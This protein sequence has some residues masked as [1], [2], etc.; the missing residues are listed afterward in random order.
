MTPEAFTAWRM[1]LGLTKEQAAKR[2]GQ[3]RFTIQN[4]ESGAS[5]LPSYIGD[6]AR[7]VEREVRQTKDDFPVQLAYSKSN[8]WLDSGG[9]LNY[10]QVEDFDRN[11]LMLRRVKELIGA[12]TFHLGTVVDQ[13]DHDIII[14]HHEELVK[15]ISTPRSLAVV[16][17]LFP[18]G[19]NMIL[20]HQCQLYGKPWRFILTI[21]REQWE[22][23]FNDNHAETA[24]RRDPDFWNFLV[25]KAAE[26]AKG[27]AQLGAGVRTVELPGLP[28]DLMPI[29]NGYRPNAR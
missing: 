3:S 11:S 14:W 26:P 15:E 4:W 8:L 28:G 5:A 2:F 13:Q 29:Y 10:V 17:A 6:L 27:E 24:Y 12:G 19:G 20:Q 25:I 7:V 22:D 21:S 9:G 18:R 23:V 1:R 16:E